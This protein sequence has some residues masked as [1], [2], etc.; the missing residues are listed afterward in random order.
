[1]D[2]LLQDLRYAL[3]N[4]ARRPGFTLLAAVT[5]AVGIGASATVFTW[6]NAVLLSP[7]PG[8][9]DPL[10]LVEVHGTSRAE[11]LI[12]MS[13]P[14][15]RDLRDGMKSFSAVVESNEQPASLTVGDEVERVWTQLVSA[16]FFDVLGVPA[17]VG[18]TFRP[19][20]DQVPGRDAV[21][22][23]SHGLWLRRFGGDP[24]LVGR[25]VTINGRAFTV[26]GVAPPEFRGSIVALSFDAWIPMAMQQQILPG[27]DRLEKRGHRWLD[28]LGRLAPGASVAQV[29]S[30]LGAMAARLA[31]DHPESNETIG[32]TAFALSD[33][34]RGA[35]KTLSPV[36]AILGVAVGLVLLIACANVASLLLARAAGRRREVAIRQALGASRARLV[37]QLMT[38]SLVL[39]GIAGVGGLLVATWCS[40]L[41]LAFVPAADFPVGIDLTVDRRA[42]AFSAAVSVLTGIL[43]GLAPALRA[44]RPD[45]VGTLKEDVAGA[46]GGRSRARFRNGLVVTQVAFSLVLLVSAGL[47]LRSLRAAQAFDLG[48]TPRGVLLGSVDLFGTGYDAEKG[49]AFARGLLQAVRAL[50]GVKAVSLARRVPLSFGGTSSTGIEVQGYAPP[51]DQQAWALYNKVGPDYFAA[52]QI[53]LIAGRDLKDEDQDQAPLVTVVNETMARRYWPDREALGGRIRLEGQWYTVV[54]VAKDIRYRRLDEKPEPVA[55]LPLLQSWSDAF[56]LHVRTDGDPSALAAP[57]RREAKRLDAAVALYAVRTLEENVKA[58]TIPQR[59]AGSLIS[60]FGVIALLLAAVGIFGVLQNAVVERTREIA[61]RLALGGERSDVLRLVLAPALRLSTTGIVIG[62][63]GA[64]GLGRL[65]SRVLFGVRA[66]DPLT[67]A[68]VAVLMFAVALIATLVP[69]WRASQVDPALALRQG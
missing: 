4:L 49:R 39:A 47:L 14:D 7:L 61:I 13:H 37:R 16:N 27:G 6:T 40:G 23:L 25:E 24:A 50:P 52:L 55:Y 63:L 66:L 58:A 42:L 46:V 9:R 15:Y 43:F 44:S 35:V 26:I 18:R 69:A 65:L 64:A 22:V 2:S 59:L 29:R 8:T 51:P 31:K 28:V 38:E 68:S 17:R 53:P 54:G 21:V 32:F 60:G 1:M 5:L 30:E 3:R 48:F 62:L 34:P 67:F 19:E 11:A 57:L 12:S 10:A 20:E 33:S 45:L 41:L 56:T 36:L